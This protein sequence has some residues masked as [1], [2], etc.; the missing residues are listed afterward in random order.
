VGII[1]SIWEEA[2]G[3]VG[4]EFLAKGIPLIANAIGGVV[5]YTREGETGW[6]NRSL[7][8]PELARIMLDVVEHPDQ[9]VELNAKIR[10]ARGTIVKPLGH[11]ADEMDAIYGQLCDAEAG[12]PA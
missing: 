6:L 12:R 10:A 1:P 8:A 2:Y 9:V 4:P 7:S 3:Y 5:E 11:H